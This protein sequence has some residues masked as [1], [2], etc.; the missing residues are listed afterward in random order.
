M[1]FATAMT[2]FL[3]KHAV[4][5]LLKLP[6]DLN[7]MF[8]MVLIAGLENPGSSSSVKLIIQHCQCEVSLTPDDSRRA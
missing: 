4:L 8:F 2:K 7:S 1:T 6:V 5:S 3:I